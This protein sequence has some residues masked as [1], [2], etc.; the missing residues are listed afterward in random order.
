MAP[1][2]L[3]ALEIWLV[4]A[5]QA[6][7]YGQLIALLLI[8]SYI[9][10]FFSPS[11]PR[12]TGS[13]VHGFRSWFEPTFLLKA[14]FITGA[15]NLIGSGYKKFRDVPFVLRRYD[16]D[17]TVLPI[18]YL[19]ELRLVPPTKLS[20]KTAQTNNLVPRWTNT[21]VILDSNLH[22]RVL[23]S[24]LNPDLPKYIDLA[25]AELEHAW[26]IEI[27]QSEGMSVCW[28]E[29]DIQQVIR[30]LVARM[31]AKVFMG[32]P[33]CRDREWLDLSID[34]SIDMFKT[35]FTLR[36]FPPWTHVIVAHFIPSRWRIKSQMRTSEK[37]VGMLMQNHAD[38]VK[39]RSQGHSDI[40]EEEDS[41]LDWMIDNGTEKETELSEMAAR[42]CILT[43]AS[44]HT[45]SM[46]VANLLF[47]LCAHP[48]WIPVLRKEVDD[49]TK[50][51]GKLGE[52][53]D[54]NT[55]QWLSKLEKMDSFMVESQRI[56]PPILLNPQRVALVPLTLKDG[57]HIPAGTRIAWAGHHHANDPNV[58]LDPKTFDPLRNYRKR[59]SSPESLSKYTAGQTD[60]NS[61]SFGY[62]NQA[63][64]GRYFAVAE[65][66][67][68]M[69]RLLCEFDLEY[70]EEQSQPRTMYADENIFTDPDAKLMMKKIVR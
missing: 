22:V 49:V 15:A 32:H 31:S 50:A 17:I 36:L 69:S 57:T 18:E 20:G 41:L 54:V 24:K 26:E 29:V 40:A 43:L 67:M 28:A 19:D 8:F 60:L 25:K 2:N 35:A 45:T 55:R 33:A 51:L 44:I 1:E 9:L 13:P 23:N 46:S 70:P 12:V 11:C 59:H 64:P 48:E 6:T 58:T 14:R 27:P 3:H 65:I 66:K 62:G 63:C 7:S 47:D 39:R 30:R 61:L 34:F 37:I 42:Q 10:S 16:V 21:Q 53:A 5:Y 38:A 68:I 56:H 4:R 52:R